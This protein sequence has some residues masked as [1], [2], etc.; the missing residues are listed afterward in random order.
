MSRQNPSGFLFQK[1]QKSHLGNKSVSTRKVWWGKLFRLLNEISGDFSVECS[2]SSSHMKCTF[3]Y[4]P[5]IILI[6]S[7]LLFL[8]RTT[9]GSISSKLQTHFDALLG[10][11]LSTVSCKLSKEEPLCSLKI[12]LKA[13][14][15]SNFPRMYL[16]VFDAMRCF[17]YEQWLWV[18]MYA[19]Y[20]KVHVWQLYCIGVCLGSGS[21][22][23][24]A[25]PMGNT[26]NLSHF[27][28][29]C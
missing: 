6:S 15:T 13:F 18:E 2:H 28:W 21:G 1:R 16:N 5:G 14:L 26:I 19:L 23:S 9:A 22:S 12:I 11:C 24:N 29:R 25:R 3:H 7:F 10:I 27:Y 4:Q 17:H 20:F 8:H